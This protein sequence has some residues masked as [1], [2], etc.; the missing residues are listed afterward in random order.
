MG[1]PLDTS[2]WALTIICL[3]NYFE[4]EGRHAITKAREAVNTLDKIYVKLKGG[5][6]TGNRTTSLFLEIWTSLHYPA[7]LG[8]GS[9]IFMVTALGHRVTYYKSIRQGNLQRREASN[10]A[11]SKQCSNNEPGT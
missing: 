11:T 2:F 9:H 6:T 5:S 4:T 7:V 3:F 10:S 1:R 8:E